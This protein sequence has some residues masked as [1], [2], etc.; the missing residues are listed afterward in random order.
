M[1]DFALGFS[2]AE[3]QALFAYFDMNKNGEVE[4]DE[5]LRQ[6]RGPMNPARKAI[7]AKAF[8]KMDADGN[9]YLDINDI[10]GVYSASKHP[11]V[12]SGKKS[13]SQILQEFLETFEAAH[14]MR[15]NTAPDHIVTKEEFDEYYNNIS[16]SIDRDDYFQLMMNSAWNLDGSRVT[17][18]GWAPKDSGEGVAAA[19]GQ[20]TPRKAVAN[21]GPPKPKSGKEYGD[22][23]L[24]SIMKEALGKRGA[25]GI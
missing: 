16:A 8:A 10:K 25:R 2:D 18:K 1:G 24:C 23:E 19:M 14:N 20:N 3:T 15:N 11:D 22:D 6:I 7:V 4:Y 5:F 13:E 21:T 12:I 17:K 9:G